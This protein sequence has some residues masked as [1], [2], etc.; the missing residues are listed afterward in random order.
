MR[1]VLHHSIGL[2]LILSACT[3]G[4]VPSSTTVVEE[5]PAT[6]EEA[7][8]ELLDA[9]DDDDYERAARLTDSRQMT[10]LAIAEGVE[11]R[12]VA[13]VNSADR[14]LIARNFWSSFHA[15]LEV[16]LGSELSNLPRGEV[17][18]RALDG[19][20]FARIDLAS[21]GDDA[22]PRRLVAREESTGWTVDLIASFPSA[23]LGLIPDAAQAIRAVGD[24]I[25]LEDLHGYE[26]SVRFILAD[27]T[28]DPLLSQAATAALESIVR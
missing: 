23:L 16:S 13:Q 12:Q 17:E 6:P 22:A 27:P 19:V 14:S 2:C 11:A 21:V 28:I 25:L 18:R 1:S 3:G 8:A 7:F 24:Q 20:E 4:T 9:L 15:Q 26:V 5:P 10:L